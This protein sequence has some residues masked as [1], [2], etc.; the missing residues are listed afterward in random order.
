MRPDKD[1][2]HW[3]DSQGS[4]DGSASILPDKGPVILVDNIGPN[5]PPAGSLGDKPGCNGLS[6]PVDPHGDPELTHWK[7]DPLNPLNISNLACGSRPKNSAGAYPSSIWQNGDHY[8]FVT[9]G[10]RFTS[11]DKR[12]HEWHMVEEQ[13]L[14]AASSR[15]NGGQW[16]ENKAIVG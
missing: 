7:K 10:F 2:Q 13:F 12:L 3:Y 14:T 16:F 6:W 5:T 8:N 4:F 9:Y 15:E 11:T 1:P